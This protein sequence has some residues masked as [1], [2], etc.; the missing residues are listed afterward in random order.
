M[1]ARMSCR[2]VLGHVDMFVEWTKRPATPANW[3]VRFGALCAYERACV[4]WPLPA[5]PRR[6]GK[7]R[8]VQ[9]N[10]L[11][12]ALPHREGVKR[13]LKNCPSLRKR[14][15]RSGGSSRKARNIARPEFE[16][17][18][19]KIKQNINNSI[20][21]KKTDLNYETDSEH[22]KTKKKRTVSFGTCA[23]ADI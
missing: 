20:N 21:I 1:R 17:K 2:A 19:N 22:L 12:Q 15:E 13:S 5:L 4:G 18:Q 23:R 16:K 8:E 14:G 10:G 11:S 9:E 7:R 6:E 3:C